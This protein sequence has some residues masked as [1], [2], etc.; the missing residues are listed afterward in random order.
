MSYL[1][2]C[3][4]GAVVGIAENRF[5]VKY[6]N[7]M[8]KSIPAETLEVIEIFGKVQLTTQ[9]LEEC[10]K[11]GVNVIFYSTYGSYYGRL[12]STSHVNVRRQRIQAEISKNE[13]FRL[14]FS[15]RII[16]AKIRNQVVILRRYA[17]TGDRDVQRP[18]AEM[19]Y[20]DSKLE[21]GKSIEQIMGYEGNAAKIYFRTL[22]NL[23]HPDFRFEK[24]T[25]RPPLDPFNPMISLGYSI[26][27]NEI[28][29]KLEAKGLNPYFGLMHKDREKHPTLASDLMEEWRAV[30]V[31]STALSMINGHEVGREEFYT[32]SE[33]PGVFLDNQAFK[34]YVQKLEQK[35]RT[36][37]K[38]LRYVNYSVSFR[39]ALDLQISQLVKALET[40]DQEAYMPVTIR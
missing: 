27:L 34:R 38:Y 13:E 37:N 2:V 20:M 11:R 33:M 6:R 7:G 12:V 22:G 21:D 25:K 29:G 35:F 4:Q 16:S 19:Q 30:L 36:D 23:I 9:C 1:Y 15:K 24:R 14:A 3:E 17:R 5:Q 8:L 18:I 39:Q 28:Y 31:D 10:L 32:T 26:I 40:G